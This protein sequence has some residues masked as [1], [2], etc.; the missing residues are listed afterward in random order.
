ML[1][2]HMKTHQSPLE[3]VYFI[4]INKNLSYYKKKTLLH[5]LTHIELIQLCQKDKDLF[6]FYIEG[7]ED[8]WFIFGNI[9]SST[10]LAQK[11]NFYINISKIKK[12]TPHGF[13]HSHASLLIHLGLMNMKWRQGYGIM[14]KQL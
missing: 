8:I 4:M 2:L 13:K 3:T 6:A 5:K 7:Y 11:L 14:L 12:I 1:L 10:N 9:I